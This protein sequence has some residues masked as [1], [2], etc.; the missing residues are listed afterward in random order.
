MAM[1]RLF[2]PWRALSHGERIPAQ[3]PVIVVANH[4]NGLVDPLLVRLVVGR[5]VAFLAKSTFWQNAW[6]RFAVESFGALPAYRAHEADTRRNEESFA[7]C[8]ALLREGGWLA[9]FP[10]GKS[11]DETTLQPMKTGAARIALGARTEG[12]A[13]LTILPMG[14]LYAA[15]ATFRSEAAVAIGEPIPVGE[16]LPS[17]R[18]AVDALTERIAEGLATV[19]LEAEDAEVWR[20][21]LAVARWTG[22]GDDLA[23]AEARARQLSGAWRR[24]VRDDPDAAERVAGRVRSFDRALRAVGVRDPYAVESS[25]P[26]LGAWVR[27][28]ALGPPALVGAALAWVPY[29]LVRPLAERLAGGHADVIG[30]FK[31]LLG[32]AVLAPVYLG[33]AAV[34]G[35]RGGPLAGA[36][37]LV[38]GPLGG[39]AA[40]RFAEIG[41]LRRE[42]LRA[43]GLRL[44]HPRLA[45]AIADR[46]RELAEEVTAALG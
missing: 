3:G 2:Y 45:F 26:S 1:L 12:A 30:T 33:W 42:A 9:L 28:L 43:M 40:L 38:V 25:P 35:A 13:G 41:A 5:P 14:L 24:L 44:F 17:D 39:L 8:R 46:R 6:T 31:L 20:A 4:P 27:W 32:F 22:A 36:A 34:A 21:L 10:E 23:A 18:E 37:L 7:A 11:H 19:V 29:R 16:G 15:K